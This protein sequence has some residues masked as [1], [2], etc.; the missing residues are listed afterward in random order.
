MK[1]TLLLIVVC[2]LLFLSWK[3]LKK[4]DTEM[5]PY[6]VI[7]KFKDFEIREYP[8]S[9]YATVSKSGKMMEIGN[10]GFRDLANYIFGGNK[11]N[12]KIAM[13]APVYI[14]SDTMNKYRSEMSFVMP[15]NFDLN[16]LPA[17]QNKEIKLWQSESVIVAVIQF[18][19]F[20]NNK[21]ILMKEEE[22]NALLIKEG[23]EHKGD[24]KY[25]SYNPPYQMMNRRNEVCVTLHPKA[26]I[27]Q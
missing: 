20:T 15:G 22:L 10:Q 1:T 25:M 23:I 27:N 2:A 21:E 6:K 5:Q 12:M 19:G 24:F 11:Q 7:K 13:T 8:P 17:P 3:A 9:V 14:Y 16:S 26:G 18:G 4:A